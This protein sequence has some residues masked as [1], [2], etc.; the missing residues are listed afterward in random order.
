MERI[1]EDIS[2]YFE[3]Q[4]RSSLPKMENKSYKRII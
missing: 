2:S 3:S 1:R 4:N